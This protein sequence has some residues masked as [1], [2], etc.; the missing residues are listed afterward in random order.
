MDDVDKEAKGM[1]G[2]PAMRNSYKRDI[3]LWY[4]GLRDECSK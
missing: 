1:S 2:L 4:I 3:T